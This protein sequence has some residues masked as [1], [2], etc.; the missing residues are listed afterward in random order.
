[1][2]KIIT[3]PMC[4]DVLRISGIEDYEVVSP[5]NI[6][7]ADIAILLSETKSDVPKLPIKLNTYTQI[8]ESVIMLRDRFN[9]TIDEDEINR[10][11]ALIEENNEKKDNRGNTKVKVYSNFLKDII[12][13]MGFT[14]TDDYDYIIIPDYWDDIEIGERKD[15]VIVP[16]HKNVSRN[17]VERVKSRYDLL[18]RKLCMKH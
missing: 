12:L 7:D 8:Y 13:D 11:L 6:K 3:T 4:E 16:S 1:M 5:D 9:T 18:E 10:I 14:I 17:I 2:M 15:C